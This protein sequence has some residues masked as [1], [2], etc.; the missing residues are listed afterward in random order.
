M[1]LAGLVQVGPEGDYPDAQPDEG[2]VHAVDLALFPVVGVLDEV[3]DHPKLVPGPWDL[4]A[5]DLVLLSSL[6]LPFL[7]EFFLFPRPSNFST[8]YSVISSSCLSN[9]LASYICSS[10]NPNVTPT[11][12]L[13]KLLISRAVP[14]LSSGMLTFRTT[15]LSH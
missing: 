2:G 6:L 11:L 9:R 4:P 1:L 10:V 7:L 5:G 8:V 13:V 15:F 12:V 3:I 14:Y